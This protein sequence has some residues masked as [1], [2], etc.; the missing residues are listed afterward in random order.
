VR[1]GQRL[2]RRSLEHRQEAEVVYKEAPHNAQKYCC[3]VYQGGHATVATTSDQQSGHPWIDSVWPSMAGVPVHG[4]QR[5]GQGA[6]PFLVEGV[7]LLPERQLLWR[8]QPLEVVGGQG[9]PWNTTGGVVEGDRH[10]GCR[11]P[12][13]R[14]EGHS[15][16]GGALITHGDLLE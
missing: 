9:P 15:G 11:L 2:L 12:T 3:G 8:R 7:G 10:I 13:K 1:S 4:L 5:D 14:S 6:L 16:F